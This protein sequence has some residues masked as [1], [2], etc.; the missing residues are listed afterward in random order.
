LESLLLCKP[1]DDAKAGDASSNFALHRS[2]KGLMHTWNMT[3]LLKLTLVFSVEVEAAQIFDRRNPA[4]AI[5]NFNAVQF[6]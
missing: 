6:Q 1:R 4:D 3:S 2:W 5:G